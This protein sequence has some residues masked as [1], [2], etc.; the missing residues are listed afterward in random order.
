[1]LQRDKSFLTQLPNELYYSI[2]EFLGEEDESQ[3]ASLGILN[4]ALSG[5]GHSK[6]VGAWCDQKAEAD[7]SALNSI[8]QMNI[9]PPSR[10]RRTG[11]AVLCK[12]SAGIC[13][14]C[15]NRAT[16]RERDEFLNLRL[17]HACMPRYSPKISDERGEIYFNGWSKVAS[18]QVKH[19]CVQFEGY[20]FI[21]RIRTTLIQRPQKVFSWWEIKELLNKGVI[22]P[23]AYRT[24]WGLPWDQLLG[25]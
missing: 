11:F 17:C 19:V 25:V 24:R 8:E 10:Y 20:E 23:K 9:I 3:Q 7:L 18:S 15:N 6:F 4:L 22:F 13:A 2:L 21:N 1:M 5:Y 12:S 16:R 14:T